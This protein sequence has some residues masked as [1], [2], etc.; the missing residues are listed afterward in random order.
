MMRDDRAVSDLVAFT[1]IFTVMIAS[2]GFIGI[3]GFDTIGDVRENEQLESG[4]VA[5]TEISD[6]INGIADHEAPVRSSEI[7]LGGG[8][9]EITDGQLINLTVS[10]DDEDIN[11]SHRRIDFGALEYRVGDQKI[12]TSGG[13]VFRSDGEN[14]VMLR[15]PPLFI[16]GDK[17]RLNFIRMEPLRTDPTIS[18]DQSIQV[19]SHHRRTAYLDPFNRDLLYSIDKIEVE[20]VDVDHRDAWERYFEQSEWSGSDG[21]YT[22]DN[23]SD[24]AIIRS[25]RI[26]IRYIR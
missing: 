12:V 9:L 25:T 13:A 4:T 7:R 21:V 24:G 20:L 17:A 6:Q 18:A 11:D 8:T 19:Q 15:E 23:P 16:K 5:M 1:L 10:Y 22:I 26:G 14:S 2:I 3:V